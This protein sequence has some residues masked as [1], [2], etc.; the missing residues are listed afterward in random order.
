MVLSVLLSLKLS[1]V[2]HVS[3]LLVVNKQGQKCIKTCYAPDLK[4]LI[5]IELGSDLLSGPP[6]S[7]T[8]ELPPD[9]PL[10]WSDHWGPQMC[11]GRVS[12]S[13]RLPGCRKNAHI[14]TP[15][16][17]LLVD[18]TLEALTT[19]SL[20]REEYSFCK[21]EVLF[22]KNADKIE[23]HPDPPDLSAHITVTFRFFGH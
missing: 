19:S 2:S 15:L 4:T 18:A 9:P 6:V 3:S 14:V 7:L 22:V 12:P 21:T 5:R 8:N 17:P 23:K 10:A 13:R 1:G 16:S 20:T 11:G